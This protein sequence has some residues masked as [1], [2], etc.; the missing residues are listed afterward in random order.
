MNATTISRAAAVGT[1]TGIRSA[2]GLAALAWRRDSPF[3]G[4]FGLFALGE[5]V[6]DKTPIVGNRTDALPL[7]GRLV[8]GAGAGGYVARQNHGSVLAGAAIG[9]ASAVV[10]AHV[11][12]RLR[13]RLPFTALG[14]AKS[15]TVRASG[16]AF[17]G[18]GR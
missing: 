1:I 15:N 17:R 16:T 11:A 10:A 18:T 9:A 4:L 6:L 14:S 5:M 8:L 2:S 7:M 12:T 3:A 13:Q